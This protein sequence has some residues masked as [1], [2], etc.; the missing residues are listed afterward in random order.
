MARKP[1]TTYE[2]GD[3]PFRCCAKSKQSGNRCKQKVVAGRRVCRYH[4]GLGGRPP[5]HGRYSKGLGRFQ[6]AYQE[7]LNDPN[8]L[9]L[10]ESL[11]LLDIC[12][13]RA[14]ER[15]GDFDTPNFRKECLELFDAARSADSPDE[16]TAALGALGKL[17]RDGKAEDEAFEQ[18]SKAA[19]K[20][21]RRQEKAWSIR[22]DAA[23]AINARDLTAVLARFADIVLEE[24]P[25]DV[26]GRIIRRIDGE[27]LGPSS[28]SVGLEVGDAT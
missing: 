9:D 13:R 3:E 19:E 12:V 24:S 16:A 25:K 6:E 5:T 28:A 26:A 14:V 4:G 1:S 2:P 18:M 17:L 22:L 8:L 10:R 15:T 23:T 7:N 21:S 11:A 27:I 20:M